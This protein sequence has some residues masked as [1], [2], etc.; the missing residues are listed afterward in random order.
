MTDLP[1]NIKDKCVP[2]LLEH[3][4]PEIF[5]KEL[6]L[7]PHQVKPVWDK[8]LY[9]FSLGTEFGYVSCAEN[10]CEKVQE[11]FPETQNELKDLFSGYV[12]GN[13]NA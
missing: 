3:L 10:L 13:T 5:M 9:A 1:Q 8:V 12:V 4:D 11:I 7:L 2:L 6:G